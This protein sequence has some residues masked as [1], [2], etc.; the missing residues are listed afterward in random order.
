MKKYKVIY[1]CYD[2]ENEPPYFDEGPLEFPS[3]EKAEISMLHSVIDELTGLNGIMEDGNFP[4]R[5]FIATMEDEE[6]DVVINCW[7]GPDY[8]PVTC[9]KAASIPELLEFFNA[10]LRKTYGLNITVQLHAYEEDDGSIWFYYTSAKYGDSDAY[11]TASEAYHE[12]DDY[13]RGVGE[14]W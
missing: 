9:Y 5:S 13:L 7:D 4:E 11:P 8:R 6:Y 2:F 12:A 3:R 10:K 14:L 1:L